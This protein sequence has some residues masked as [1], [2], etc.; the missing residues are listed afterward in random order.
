MQT[1]L[2]VDNV[3]H[4]FGGLKAVS[5]FNLELP[6]GSLWGLIG[7]NGAGKT[8]IFNLITGVYIPTQG[9]IFLLDKDITKDKP[10]QVVAKGIARTFQN[11]R[12]FPTLTVLDNIRIAGHFKVKY[13]LSDAIIRDR[14]YYRSEKDLN[15]K[16]LHLLEL[17]KLHDRAY[18]PAK[19]LPYG[20][21]RRLEIARALA[22][23][24]KL[25]L[26]DEPAAGMNPKE[27]ENLM[28]MIL[29]IREH[30]KI[31]VYLIEHHMK[32]VMGICERIKVMDFGETIAEGNADEI[33]NNPRVIE[34][35]LGRRKDAKS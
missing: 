13:G 27:V 2:R 29:W 22:T 30:F 24:P 4:Y 34:A 6:E 16:A 20:E 26:L 33:Q 19:S 25:L 7:P 17:F 14:E 1:V 3:T 5:N 28:E 31:T 12:I 9:K 32:V 18:S 11:L 8:T 10:H 15:E 35:Y 23:D 21:L